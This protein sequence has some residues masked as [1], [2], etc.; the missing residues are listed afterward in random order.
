MT[1]TEKFC[2]KWNDFEENI[3]TAFV[4]LR[5]DADFV[6]VTLACEDGQQAEAHKVILAASSPYFQN[7][8]RRNKHAHPLIYMRGM[9]S[10]NLLA[11]VDFFFIMEKQMFIKK[12]L[13]VS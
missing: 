1:N 9:K 11:I 2:L 8:L 10:E 6:N 12:T 7:L 3:S 13:M 4:S 5:T